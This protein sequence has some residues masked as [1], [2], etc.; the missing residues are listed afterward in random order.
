MVK[1][2]LR[3]CLTS[4][5]LSQLGGESEG[6]VDGQ[7]GLDVEEWGT[8]SLLLREDHT[9][10]LVQHSVDS[11]HSLLW[12]LNL[13]Q[14]D[15]LLDRWLGEKGRSVDDTSAGW[16]DL[17]TSSVDGIGVEDDIEDVESSSSHV[18][19]GDWTL[20]GGPLE[21]GNTR[22][23]DLV[24]VSDGLGL[25]D[26]QVWSGGVWSETPNLSCV[27][28]VPLVVVSKV[29]GSGLEIISWVDL[30]GLNIL[31][32]LLGDWLSDHEDSVVLVW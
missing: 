14:E 30:S 2:H 11:S 21:G 24:Q 31:G 22:I 4:G 10:L 29:S 25:V 12:A 15:W 32:K 18:L 17:T 6:L 13:D 9:S 1:D 7:V 23:L 20:L 19:L 28:D 8:W 26:D 3:E 27:G 16:D 5:G